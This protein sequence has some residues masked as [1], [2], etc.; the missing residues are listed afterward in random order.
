M[1]DVYKLNFLTGKRLSVFLAIA[2]RIV[3]PDGDAPGAG[4]MLTAGVVDW[5]LVRLPE[6]LRKRLLTLIILVEYMGVF[7]GGRG[8]T[9][10]S[11]KAQ[12]RQLQWM[13]NSPLRLFRQGFFGLKTYVCMG[14]YTREDVWGTFDYEGPLLPEREFADPVIRALCQATMEVEE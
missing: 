7:F 13:E 12:T 6:D 4:A 3:P 5:A 1:P 14:Y 9:S 2:D 8:F 10:N 11:E